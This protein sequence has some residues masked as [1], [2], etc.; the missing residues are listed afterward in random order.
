MRK[1]GLIM[2]ALIFL[3]TG[4]AGGMIGVPGPGLVWEEECTIYDDL[5]IQIVDPAA[6]NYSLIATKI[7]NPC[8]AHRLLVTA[9]KIPAVWYEKEYI[10]LFEQWAGK[11]QVIVESGISYKGLQDYIILEVGKLNSQAGITLLILSDGIF[12]FNEADLM[13][14]KDKTLVLMSLNDL[15]KKVANMGIMYSGNVPYIPVS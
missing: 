6:P 14:P 1:L 3:L 5:E 8:A 11:V 2:S 9:V 10:D 15:R 13:L 7:K 12:V 4:C